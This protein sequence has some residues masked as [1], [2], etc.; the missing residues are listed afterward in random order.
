MIRSLIVAFA[1]LTVLTASDG[2]SY[3]LAQSGLQ[4]SSGVALNDGIPREVENVTVEQK[5]GEQVPL[6]L[7]LY[8]S[9]GRRVKTGFFIDGKKPTIVSLNYSSCPMLCNVQLNQL[10][11]SLN[12][13]NLKIGEDFQ[14]L[15]VSIDPTESSETIRKTKE[16]YV[17]QLIGKHPKV[18]EGWA[19]CTAQQPIITNL[20]DKLGFKYTY[21][22]KSGEY[23]HP[24][25]LAFVSPKGVI[26]RYSLAV[27][28]EPADLKK[29]IVEA[30]DGTVGS[31]V[32]QLILWCF[33]YDPTSNSYVPQ[34]W[35]IMR[36]SGA[37]TILIMLACLAP[38]W[39]GR[40]RL[41]TEDTEDTPTN[42]TTE[43]DPV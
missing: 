13:L 3:A 39:I 7:P 33:S 37:A 42:I 15:T 10:T 34:A 25:M 11:Q 27:A 32:D 22:R 4:D 21:D 19:F 8:D 5:L 6:N 26:T 17:E 9:L 14:I 23:Y 40:K 12:E 1:T 2:G 18:E 38:F 31:P 43:P 20:A 35:K 29:A 36:I 41:P 16:K 28:F 30:G 24:A